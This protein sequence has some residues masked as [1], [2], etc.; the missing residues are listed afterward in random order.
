MT[1][2]STPNLNNAPESY[3]PLFAM[4]NSTQHAPESYYP[5]NIWRAHLYPT[6]FSIFFFSIVLIMLK[7]N[8][9]DT[10]QTVLI[11]NLSL[12]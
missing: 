6:H 7:L 11:K 10:L 5:F 1:T 3:Y 9:S 4:P 8:F 2:E 12:Q